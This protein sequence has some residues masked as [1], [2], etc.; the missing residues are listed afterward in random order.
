MQSWNLISIKKILKTKMISRYMAN[1]II[2]KLEDFFFFS[3][4]SFPESEGEVSIIYNME[5][6]HLY[7]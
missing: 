5:A 1:L 2:N 6:S 3:R 7:Q 4:I